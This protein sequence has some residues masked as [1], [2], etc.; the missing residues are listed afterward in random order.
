MAS[1]LPSTFSR[2]TSFLLRSGLDDQWS[3]FAFGSG[4]G[5]AASKVGAASDVEA[6]LSDARDPVTILRARSWRRLMS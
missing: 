4:A 5:G 1:T 2:S 6:T 3:S